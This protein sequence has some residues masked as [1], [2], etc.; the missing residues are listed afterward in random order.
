[1]VV[2]LVDQL[3]TAAAVRRL[4]AAYATAP[5]SPSRP[6]GERRATPSCWAPGHFAA[7]A[8]SAVGDRGARDY[9]RAHPGLVTRVPCDDVA[10]PDDIDT[11]EDLAAF[12]RRPGGPR[13]EG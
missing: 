12:D 13:A 3:V 2:A 5:K 1:M 8:E 10:A 6:T 11:P 7:A 9:L 4:I